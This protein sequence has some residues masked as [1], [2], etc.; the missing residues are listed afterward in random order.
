[1]N[2]RCL[3][4]LLRSKIDTLYSQGN[5]TVLDSTALDLGF[6][7]KYTWEKHC[8]NIPEFLLAILKIKR[9]STQKKK[10]KHL[11]NALNEFTSTTVG[12]VVMWSPHNN[13]DMEI[14]TLSFLIDC[15]KTED[16]EQNIMTIYVLMYFARRI[17][18]RGYSGNPLINRSLNRDTVFKYTSFRNVFAQKIF[19]CVRLLKEEA[20]PF[21]FI[22]ID[23]SIRLC[24]E[25][26]R[27]ITGV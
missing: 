11:L 10:G 16:I 14:D 8:L 27:L 4:H 17:L 6:E 7:S 25:T 5:K 26:R 21:P 13:I 24:N 20:T 19:Q 22:F 15:L 3:S 1:M 12:K 9:L 2:I 23:R 18:K